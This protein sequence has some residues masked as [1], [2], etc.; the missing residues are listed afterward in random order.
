M[1]ASCSV[2]ELAIISFLAGFGRNVANLG[3][4]A[5][6]ANQGVL[7]CPWNLIFTLV[8]QLRSSLAQLQAADVALNN[9]VVNPVVNPAINQGFAMPRPFKK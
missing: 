4:Q 1:H 5:A 2:Y 7:G 3:F 9:G 8:D 6:A